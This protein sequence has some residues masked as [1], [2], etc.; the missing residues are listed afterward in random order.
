M[1]EAPKER[2]VPNFDLERQPKIQRWKYTFNY[3]IGAGDVNHLRVARGVCGVIGVAYI[4]FKILDW[5]LS[6]FKYYYYYYF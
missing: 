4:Y 2:K 1:A 5:A 6:K 3:A